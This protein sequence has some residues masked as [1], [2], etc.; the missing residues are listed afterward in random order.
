MGG[1]GAWAAR[2]LPQISKQSSDLCC[3]RPSSAGP[4]LNFLG[5]FAGVAALTDVSAS[6]YPPVSKHF[7]SPGGA[8]W[9]AAACVACCQ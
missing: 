9:S 3:R 8:E 4:T 6:S 1:G 7:M 5:K 2:A